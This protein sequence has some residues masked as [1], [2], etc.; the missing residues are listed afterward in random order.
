MT[1]RR[2]IDF[3]YFSGLCK[4]G[5]GVPARP[6]V[7]VPVRPWVGGPARPGVGVPV[8]PEVGVPVR[9]GVGVTV[10]SGHQDPNPSQGTGSQYLLL[11]T[12]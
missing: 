1:H 12:H 6:G 9:L 4:L 5:V 7:G 3:L 2:G 8:R 11:T 10:A